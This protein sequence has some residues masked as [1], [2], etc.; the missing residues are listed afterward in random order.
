MTSLTLRLSLIIQNFVTLQAPEKLRNFVKTD[1]NT[2]KLCT[3]LFL[4]PTSDNTR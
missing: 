1:Q 2:T 3:R 4:H